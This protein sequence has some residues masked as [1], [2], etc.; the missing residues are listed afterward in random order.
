MTRNHTKLRIW[1]EAH[2]L[3]V[4]LY[5]L[6]ANFPETEK[7]GLVQQIRRAAASVGANIAEGCGQRTKPSMKR[8]LFMSIGSIKELENHMLLAK[9]L[10]Y[11]TPDTYKYLSKKIKS[12]GKMLHN[13]TNAIS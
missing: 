5:E 10:E 2:A 7:F 6:T 4:K 11:I 3:T 9:D 1:K 13:F 8:Y 12:L